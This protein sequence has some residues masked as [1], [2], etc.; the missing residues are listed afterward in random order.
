MLITYQ[1]HLTSVNLECSCIIYFLKFLM[2]THSGEYSNFILLTPLKGSH[3]SML[4]LVYVCV[5]VCASVCL[6]A[7]ISFLYP[8]YFHKS[9]KALTV[10]SW[11]QQ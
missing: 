10:G 8:F 3:L 6:S 4:T 11:L 9:K 1:E 2:F 7:H 5:C